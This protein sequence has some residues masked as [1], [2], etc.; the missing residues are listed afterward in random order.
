MVIHRNE[1][2]IMMEK[3]Y[4]TFSY[5]NKIEEVT[6]IKETPKMLII[7]TDN[8]GTRRTSKRSSYGNY[9]KT[10]QEAVNQR[11]LI[12]SRSVENLK[13]RLDSAKKTL[14]EFNKSVGV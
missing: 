10:P 9:F 7:K 14:V 11:R 3:W 5:G 6:V 4:T 1:R 13:R 8:G 12:L 2:R